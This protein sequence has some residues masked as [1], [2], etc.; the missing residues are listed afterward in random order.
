MNYKEKIKQSVILKK[1][2]LRAIS[3]KNQARPRLWV[4]W[5]I[6]PFYMKKGKGSCIRRRSRMDILPF[7]P[8]TLGQNSTIEDFC[9]VNNGVGKISIGNNSRVGIG[10][11]L[12][13]PVTI[14]DHVGIA[15]NVVITAL[16][17]NYTD[18]SKPI[19]LQGV[20]TQ[21]VYIGDGTWIGANSV[22]LPGVF[23]GNHCVVGA[24]S[25]VVKD[26][27]SYSVILGNPARVVKRFNQETE[28]WDKV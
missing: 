15:Q 13:G 8:F 2:I 18:I 12:I 19:S 7:N 22:I 4:K 27:P 16:N 25:V 24:G 3:P 6:N 23:I 1:I 5:F 11:V 21:E 28:K 26:V 20:N 10:S 9:T 17:H 14:G